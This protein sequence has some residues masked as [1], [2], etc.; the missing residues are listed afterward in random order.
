MKGKIYG[1]TFDHGH[2]TRVRYYGMMTKKAFLVLVSS[3]TRDSKGWI[4]KRLSET[5]NTKEVKNASDNPNKLFSEAEY[6]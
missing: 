1:Y 5:G 3:K 4:K 2:G 6:Q